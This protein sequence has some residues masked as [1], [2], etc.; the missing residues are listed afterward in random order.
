[1]R[2]CIAFATLGCLQLMAPLGTA[3]A[4]DDDLAALDAKIANLENQNATLKKRLRLEA[5]EKENA[6]LRNVTQNAGS[7]FSGRRR[8]EF[9][10]IKMRSTQ[11]HSGL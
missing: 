5:L 9:G 1:M 11:A 4:Q 6:A 2:R 10:L 8:D 7:K 3:V